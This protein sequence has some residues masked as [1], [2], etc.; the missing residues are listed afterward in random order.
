MDGGKIKNIVNLES[1]RLQH[2]GRGKFAIIKSGGC[3]H[4]FN[5]SYE[6]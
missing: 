3:G 4:N 2:R 6:L 5:H 1:P